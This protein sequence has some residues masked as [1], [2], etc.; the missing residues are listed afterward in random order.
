M[1]LGHYPYPDYEPMAFWGNRRRLD[2]ILNGKTSETE[3]ES[4]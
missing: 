3:D 1:N 2:Q 4:E